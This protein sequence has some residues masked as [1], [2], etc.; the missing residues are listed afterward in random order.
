MKKH[1][2]YIKKSII[3]LAMAAMGA[4]T[5]SGQSAY[6]KVAEHSVFSNAQ[7][8]AM[9]SDLADLRIVPGLHLQS[10][11]RQ[12]FG[13]KKLPTYRLPLLRKDF[14]THKRIKRAMAYVCG[15]GHFDLFLNGQKVGDHFLDCGWTLYSKEALY[16]TFDVTA[17]LQRGENTVGVMLGNGFYNVP[18]DRYFKVLTSFGAPKLLFRLE[19]TYSDGSQDEICSDTSWKVAQSPITFSSIYG[20]EDYDAA[21]EQEGWTMPQ[22]DDSEWVQALQT[23]YEGRLLPQQAEPLRVVRRLPAKRIFQNK[24]GQWVYDLGQNFSGIIDVRLSS[25]KRQSVRFY[26]AEL[27]NGDSTVN[28]R[29]SGSPYFLTYTTPSAALKASRLRPRSSRIG[30]QSE[31]DT[32]CCSI[33]WRPQFTYYGFRFVQIEGAVPAGRANPDGLPVVEELAGLHTTAATIPAGHFECSDSLFNRIYELIDWA[34][35][36]NVASVITDCPHREKLGWLEQDY[37]MQAS[38]LY[39]YDLSGLYAKLMQD[40]QSSQRSNGCIPTI[41]PEYVRFNGGF[42]DTP[43]W[44]SAFIQIPWNIWKFYGDD[45]LIRRYYTDMKN[46]LAYLSSRAEGHILSYGLG[47]WYDIGPNPPGEAQLTSNS[48]TATATYYWDTYLLSQM[49][50]M[51]GREDDRTYFQQLASTIKIAFRKRFFNGDGTHVENDSQTGLSIVLSLGLADS[52][53]R[54]KIYQH[55]VDNIT[56]RNYALNAGDVGYRYVLDALSQGGYSDVVLKMNNRNDVPGYGWQL[57]HGATALTESW[58]AYA[59]VSNNHLMLGHLMEWFYAWLGGIRQQPGSA[60]FRQ[61]LIDPQLVGDICWAETSWRSP[62]GIIACR[63]EK[64]ENKITIRVTIPKGSSAK[65]ILPTT[66]RRTVKI[67]R[68]K[69]GVLR[70]VEGNLHIEVD[71]REGSYC[72]LIEK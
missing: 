72:F 29:A 1:L 4:M 39:C 65:V 8:I 56:S 3:F 43:E 30:H 27:L 62:Q 52:I 20:G 28:Q 55:L 9:E 38:M 69:R 14:K 33:H 59:N 51:L 44:G 47:D 46:Y 37:L 48:L 16:E 31:P 19:I 26:P 45:R 21:L 36:S 63:W 22:F 42:E 2:T 13:D 25:D 35:R 61:I 71:V 41:A 34:I 23:T 64:T 32:T 54:P 50:G 15:L 24:Y 60:G 57:D 18:H 7:W 11:V 49:A 40:M 67:S 70:V 12:V 58:Q 17:L 5:L 68:G 53:E 10:G 66:D 6:E